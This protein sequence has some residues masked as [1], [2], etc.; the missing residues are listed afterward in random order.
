MIIVAGYSFTIEKSWILMNFML[1]MLRRKHHIC[2]LSV[3]SVHVQ[4]QQLQEPQPLLTVSLMMSAILSFTPKDRC[5]KLGEQ[6]KQVEESVSLEIFQM[7]KEYRLGTLHSG[8]GIL[9]L[10]VQGN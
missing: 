6:W 4:P 10:C 2:P 8:F 5:L 9:C 1:K 7:G 3:I